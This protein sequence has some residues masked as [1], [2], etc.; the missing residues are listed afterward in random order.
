MAYAVLL[1]R[2]AAVLCGVMLPLLLLLPC[3]PYCLEEIS[4]AATRCK[5]C[6]AD[7]PLSEEMQR[8]MELAAAAL[9]AE[10]ER[11]QQ[12]WYRRMFAPCAKCCCCCGQEHALAHEDVEG[13]PQLQ[14]VTEAT[15]PVVMS[16][17]RH[18]MSMTGALQRAYSSASGQPNIIYM[19]PQ[20]SFSSSAAAGTAINMAELMQQEQPKD[21]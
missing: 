8:T 12:R 7:V 18:S 16:P 2:S 10:E 9:I 13:G 5:H 19:S 21:K 15:G 17:M 1:G 3:S 4:M 6:A 20:Q 14:P 11:R